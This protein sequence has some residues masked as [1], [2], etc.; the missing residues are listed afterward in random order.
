MILR[1]RENFEEK[2]RGLGRCPI[3]DDVIVEPELQEFDYEIGA[4]RTHDVE[5]D[6][7]PVQSPRRDYVMKSPVPFDLSHYQKL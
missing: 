4:Q 2:S 7:T 6:E 1:Q 5:E 3:V